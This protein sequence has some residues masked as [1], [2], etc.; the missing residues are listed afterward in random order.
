MNS[1]A[2][3]CGVAL[4]AAGAASPATAFDQGDWLIR[5]GGSYIDPSSTNHEIVKVDTAWSATFNFTYMMT[6]NW[7]VEVLAAWPFEHDINLIDGPRVASTRQ[8]P[9]TVSLQYHFLPDSKF[10]PYVG[11]GFNYTLFFDEKTTGALEGIDLD[12]DSSMGLEGEVGLDILLNDK[13]FLNFDVRYVD[14]DSD[15]KL[16]GEGIGTV[17]IDPWVY[18]AN[19]GFRF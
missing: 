10:Q 11:V 2:L 13:W 3:L 14:I 6:D 15:A 18:G 7:A 1:K 17:R 16:N 9:P 12:L 4:L 19:V 5:F 8:L